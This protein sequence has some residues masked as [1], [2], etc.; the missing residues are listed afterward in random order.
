M[1]KKIHHA[2]TNQRKVAVTTLISDKVDFRAK[3]IITGSFHN[4]NGVSLSRGHN[5][6]K[7]LHT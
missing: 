1:E 4:D 6:F 2:N 7:C 3:N 5:T